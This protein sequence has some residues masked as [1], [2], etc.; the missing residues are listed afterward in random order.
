M[1]TRLPRGV[2]KGPAGWRISVRVGDRLFQK[3]FKPSTSQET[4]E[5][6]L[7]KARKRWRAGRAE[8]VETPSTLAGD[9]TDY[10]EHYFAGRAGL[11]ERTRHLQLWIDALDPLTSNEAR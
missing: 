2:T 10:L 9:V 11:K 4:V 3:R 7:S 6:E 8:S 1:S 5:E